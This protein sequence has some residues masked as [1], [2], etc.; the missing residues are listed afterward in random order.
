M[1]EDL[2]AL[3]ER[4]DRLLQ[5]MERLARINEALRA[6]L[7]SCHQSRA[8]LEQRM[9]AASDKVRSALARLPADPPS[10]HASGFDAPLT[11]EDPINRSN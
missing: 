10:D 2:Q 9:S 8:L 6:E 3:Q 4:L 5:G 11:V 7:A 1:N